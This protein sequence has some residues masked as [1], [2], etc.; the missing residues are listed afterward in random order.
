MRQHGPFPWGSPLHRD[1][2]RP[3]LSDFKPFLSQDT[4]CALPI[5]HDAI[6][7][8]D[9]AKTLRL[10][11]RGRLTLQSQVAVMQATGSIDRC[12]RAKIGRSELLPVKGVYRSRQEAT[13]AVQ[14]VLRSW[15]KG[16]GNGPQL[17]LLDEPFADDWVDARFVKAGRDRLAVPMT[18]GV[19]RPRRTAWASAHCGFMRERMLRLRPRFETR[20]GTHH[21]PRELGRLRA[22]GQQA[23]A[24]VGGRIDGLV[25]AQLG[26][27][28]RRGP[29]DAAGIGGRG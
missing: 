20:P 12:V 27:E 13:R 11:K 23:S 10:V 15:A 8:M 6:G 24:H 2:S 1:P 16:I 18:I 14:S 29:R 17:L 28:Q 3:T 4:Q 5:A 25:I 21:R 26:A 7:R 19:V 9:Y 22:H